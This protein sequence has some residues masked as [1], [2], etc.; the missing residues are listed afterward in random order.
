MKKYYG[1]FV[2]IVLAI[3]F[4]T[5]VQ[6]ESR[7]AEAP[8]AYGEKKEKAAIFNKSSEPS[9][10]MAVTR[11]DEAKTK[12]DKNAESGRKGKKEKKRHSESDESLRK[13]KVSRLL[14]DPLGNVDGLLLDTGAIVTFPKHA[15][16]RLTTGVKPG[17]TLEVKGKLEAANQIKG[18]VIT[19]TLSNRS[20]T[21]QPPQKGAK[22]IPKSSQADGLQS[23]S[24]QGKIEYLRHNKHGEINGV[25]LADGTI[26]HFSREASRQFAPMLKIGQNI[27]VSGHGTRNQ[28]GQ[29][30]EAVALGPAEQSS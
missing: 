3:I 15:S 25:I 17:D 10:E 19:N 4:A 1:I 5:A 22:K 29:A 30:I 23:M 20:L 16:E 14:I 8:A 21:A 24:A 27:S 7:V 26:V 11:S 2:S 12:Q 6:A 18:Y 28:H 9:A 13:G